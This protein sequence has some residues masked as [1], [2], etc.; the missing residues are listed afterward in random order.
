MSTRGFVGFKKNNVIRGWY[1]HGDSY[2]KCLGLKVL[3]KYKKHSKEV[4]EKFFLEYVI[5]TDND[6]YYGNHRSVFNLDW[7]KD[8]V[9]LE[10]QSD[11]ILDGL[12]CEYAYVFNLDEDIVEVYR[13]FFKEP[14]KPNQKAKD[15]YYVNNVF[16]I[17]RKNVNEV[18]DFFNGKVDFE[19][20]K[21]M[22]ELG[23]IKK[24][25]N[26]EKTKDLIDDFY[27]HYIFDE[28]TYYEPVLLELLD[29]K[30]KKKK[31]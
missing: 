17:T 26:L 16:N 14:K 25:M 10:E 29:L 30:N 21:T 28:Q 5:L 1:N 2:Y 11:F 4:L 24:E 23:Y 27:V 12:F 9:V 22:Y 8:K 13:G 15:K 6:K 18:E 3:E 20:L 31:D 7:E 19:I